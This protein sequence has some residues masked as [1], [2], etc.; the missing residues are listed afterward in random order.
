MALLFLLLKTITIVIADTSPKEKR[1][2]HNHAKELLSA[3]E[4]SCLSRVALD[5]SKLF[6]LGC[7]PIL[8]VSLLSLLLVE[9]FVSFLLI[10]LFLSFCKLLILSTREPFAGIDLISICQQLL[11]HFLIA[12]PFLSAVA[13]LVMTSS[14]QLWLR[15]GRI[16]STL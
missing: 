8:E 9:T 14:P 16:F 5:L 11:T 2:I 6:G 15:F 4:E 10:K 3:F 12:V 1:K 13:G 7:E